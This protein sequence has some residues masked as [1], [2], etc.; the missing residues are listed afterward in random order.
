MS[1]SKPL[2]LFMEG[3]GRIC[4][5]KAGLK[6]DAFRTFTFKNHSFNMKKPILVMLMALTVQAW[7]HT[8]T[9]QTTYDSQNISFL[10]KWDNPAVPAEPNYGIRYNGIWG[11]NDG[12]GREY[13]LIGSTG[14]VY[15]IDVTNPLTPVVADYV[16]GRRSGC[17]W[18]EIKT[19]DHYAYLVSDDS[20]PNSLQIVDL[21]YLPDSVHVVYDDNT[22]F[23]R[24]HTIFVEDGLLYGGIV[25]G[26]S[27]AGSG[28]QGNMSVFDLSNPTNPV[29]LRSIKNDYPNLLPTNQVH[30]MYVRNDTIY[31]S[32]SFDGLFIFRYNRTTNNFVLLASLTSYPGQGYN[33]SSALTD[34]GQTL[35]F[36]D[37]VPNGL[38]VKVL[39]VSDLSNLTVTAT[40]Q[41][42]PG[43]T[44]HNPFIVGNT[45]YI[46][47]Y[48]DGLQVYDVANPTNPVRLGYFDTHNQTAMGGPYPSPAYQGAWGAYPYLPSGR[49]LVSDMQNGLFVL[50]PSAMFS[51]VNETV[52]G[53]SFTAYPNPVANGSSVSI[54][55][56]DFKA[57]NT[58][59]VRML[60]I[61]GRLVSQQAI[62]TA[63][64]SISTQGMAAGCYFVEVRSEAGTGIRKVIVE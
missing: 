15:F 38:P 30:D 49:V 41:S 56:P 31:A 44:P 19:Y 59:E 9:A 55:L 2:I 23:E 11:W 4:S 50:D 10:S 32:S 7:F 46:A 3:K 43:P 62:S 24:C 20:P 53:L 28:I 58:Y 37:E 8:A 17:I 64:A 12:A 6:T 33:H 63:S 21:Q 1:S 13:A 26:G 48:Q 27:F 34:D 39:D 29:F 40:F 42:N 45:C 61:D 18:R 22:L 14:G 57:G 5:Q 25:S 51:G 47:Y 16:P 54:S 60:S 35:V 52:G 36:M